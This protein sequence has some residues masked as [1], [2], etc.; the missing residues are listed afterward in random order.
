M[1]GFEIPPRT[2]EVLRLMALHTQGGNA[3]FIDVAGR[4][5]DQD[6]AIL[7]CAAVER[8]RIG[9]RAGE[10]IRKEG[11]QSALGAVQAKAAYFQ[12]LRP[13]DGLAWWRLAR[14]SAWREV[15]AALEQ[16]LAE[17]EISAPAEAI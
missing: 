1:S 10:A 3:A 11:P 14:L 8:A 9:L 15:A 5:N 17:A 6:R 2:A 7:Y 12:R 16:D 4:T 13:L